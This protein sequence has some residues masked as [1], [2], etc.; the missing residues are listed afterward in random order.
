MDDKKRKE[1]LI[2][3]AQRLCGKNIIYPLYDCHKVNKDSRAICRGSDKCE[4][5]K[6][7]L[8]QLKYIVHPLDE[9]CYL[10]ACPG[11]GK[12]HVVGL[13]AAYE[14][15]DWKLPH[16]GIAFLSFTRNAAAEI[17]ERI[18]KFAGV[19]G[20]KHPHFVGTIDSWL[21]GFI[22]HPFAHYYAGFKGKNGDKS[23]RIVETSSEA[24]F[25][26]SFK[27]KY[28]YN[29]MQILANKFFYDVGDDSFV[30]DKYFS[31]SAF[32]D[33]QKADLFDTK[34][35]FFHSGLAIF[36]D[37]EFICSKLFDK[38]PFIIKLFSARFPFIVID[39]CQDLSPGQL[40]I[41]EFLTREGTK[42]HFVGD[43]NQ[44]IY[45][46][47]R[48][49]P[50][51]VAVFVEKHNFKKRKLINNY[52]S[53]QQIVNACSNLVGSTEAIIGIEQEIVNDPCRIW[54]YDKNNLDE[55]RTLPE[56]FKNLLS[57]N[58]LNYKK[59]AVLARGTSLLSILRPQNDKS[60]RSS[61]LFAN[62]LTSWN[63][64][65]R[66]TEDLEVALN[67]MG[68]FFG[69]YAFKKQMTDH[70]NQYCPEGLLSIAWR[71]FL[72]DF[73][74]KSTNKLYPFEDEQS[75][76]LT[77]S[78]WVNRK[79]K[80][81]LESRWSS[82][83]SAD[84]NWYDEVVRRIKAPSKKSQE[85]MF[86]PTKTARSYTDIR[87]TTIHK[88]KG[89]TLDAVMLVSSTDRRGSKGGYWTEWL[90][91]KVGEREHTRFA[92]VACSRAKHL[93][94]VAV[95]RSND[96]PGIQKLEKLGF[97]IQ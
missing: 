78:E 27:T 19:R 17:C 64:I 67:Q 65:P 85:S 38:Y 20:T 33:W 8:D 36:N 79:L 43:L 72:A 28:R 25:L 66:T 24:D 31:D 5:N 11:S 51:K 12:T 73:L 53:N 32:T 94:I 6:L 7:N 55:L 63:Q 59:A 46:F 81:H 40:Y 96:E 84:T 29:R 97:T 83:P 50:E 18:Q 58:G 44:A 3:V 45:E 26:H 93:L 1:L 68:R 90:E 61:E 56:R 13:K 2:K 49:Y 69:L 23:F 52:R 15:R 16:S 86:P 75:N 82:I 41:L 77:W 71:R 35:R 89:E 47:R 48:V 76:M 60:L 42:L 21:H 14:I 92:Y 9:F 37:I 80:P 10:Q 4:I 91:P 70:Q 22:L 62:A 95:P 34:E 87:I 57:K 30:F 74:T 39:E 54:R 88:V